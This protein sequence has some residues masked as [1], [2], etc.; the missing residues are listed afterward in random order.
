MVHRHL[1]HM[2]T[3]IPML[4]RESEDGSTNV[5]ITLPVEPSFDEQSDDIT[6]SV[7]DPHTAAEVTK[8]N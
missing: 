6:D 1:D 7:D 4:T 5:D 2:R 8:N 3:G